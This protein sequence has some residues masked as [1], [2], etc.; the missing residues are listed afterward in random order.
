MEVA[1][2]ITPPRCGNAGGQRSPSVIMKTFSLDDDINELRAREQLGEA[3]V[4]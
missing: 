4:S 2:G 3:A 1:R